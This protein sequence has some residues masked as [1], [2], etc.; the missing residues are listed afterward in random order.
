MLLSVAILAFYAG[1]SRADQLHRLSGGQIRAQLTGKVLTDG[2]HWRETY[3]SGGKLLAAEMDRAT[4]S[5]SW[6]IEGDRLC[7]KRTGILDNCYEVWGAGDR[8]EI[9]LGD[10][11]PLEA[12]LRSSN[13][14]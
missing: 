10:S 7:K 4:S 3:A 1:A 11:P 14:K 12:F 2:A 8:T 5:G 13:Q 9:R 6:R